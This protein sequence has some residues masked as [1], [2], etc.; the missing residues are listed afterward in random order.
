MTHFSLCCNS[1]S[2]AQRVW[3]RSG[4]HL[5]GTGKKPATPTQAAGFTLVELLVATSISVLMILG[6]SY[7]MGSLGRQSSRMQQEHNSYLNLEGALALLRRDIAQMGVGIP[8]GIFGQHPVQLRIPDMVDWVAR[9]TFNN[10]DNGGVG[11]AWG[12]SPGNRMPGSDEIWLGG[13]GM[14]LHPSSQKSGLAFVSGAGTGFQTYSLFL[15]ARNDLASAYWEGYGGVHPQAAFDFQGKTS[16]GM[17]GDQVIIFAP[18]FGWLS[19]NTQGINLNSAASFGT[20]NN[21]PTLCGPILVDRVSAAA[22]YPGA[23]QVVADPTSTRAFWANQTTARAYAIATRSTSTSAT[24]NPVAVLTAAHWYLRNDGTLMRRVLTNSTVQCNPV[25]CPEM[26]ILTGVRDFQIAYLL[27][28]CQGTEPIWVS[29][30]LYQR[31][32][33]G[34]TGY[35]VNPSNRFATGY[36]PGSLLGIMRRM[37]ILRERLLALRISL[38]IEVPGEKPE[39]YT[40]PGT[41]LVENHVNSGLNPRSYYYLVQEVMDPTNLRLKSGARV[42]LPIRS[43]ADDLATFNGSFCDAVCTGNCAQ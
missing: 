6:V 9:Y 36:P 38:L 3:R 39:G 28:P 18:E 31:T 43:V 37:M 33:G 15:T 32:A 5:E 14:D 40:N 27:W 29:D 7:F 10:A 25:Q 12:G 4:F 21:N 8:W 30:L 24:G 17:P 11:N 34:E 19:C 41:I 22:G 13:V 1:V 16:L 2:L 23:L 42:Y 20:Y 35:L 26:P